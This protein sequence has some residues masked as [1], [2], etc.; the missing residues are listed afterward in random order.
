MKVMVYV[1]DP[2]KQFFTQVTS[3]HLHGDPRDKTK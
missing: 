2:L 1:Q 3:T